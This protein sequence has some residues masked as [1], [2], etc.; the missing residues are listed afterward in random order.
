MNSEAGATFR[1]T[2]SND[3]LW[4]HSHHVRPGCQSRAHDL[5]ANPHIFNHRPHF[6][7]V[8]RVHD[9]Y[10]MRWVFY[11]A[12]R[13]DNSLPHE[14]HK[15]ALLARIYIDHPVNSRSR[16]HPEQVKEHDAFRTAAPDHDMSAVGF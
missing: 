5:G 14:W 1:S 4:N 9:D 7:L 11:Q 6:A 13:A 16:G 10:K 8:L 15:M 2:N 12:A 3:L